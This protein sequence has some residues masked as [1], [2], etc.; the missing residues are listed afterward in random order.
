MNKTAALMLCGLILFGCGK[1]PTSGTKTKNTNNVRT[2]IDI[3][4]G[5]NGQYL[6][7]FEALNEEV[8]GRITGAF[9]FSRDTELDEVVGDV[10]L[11]N[12]GARVVHAQSVRTG[13][14]CPTH[15]D[16][17]NQDGIIDAKEGEA[18]YGK[19]LFPLDGDLSTQS[20]HD[21]EY[22]VGDI[23]G[24]YIYSK[25]SSFTHFVEDLRGPEEYPDYVKLKKD[26]P[27]IIEGK[28]A[29]IQGLNDAIP[30]PLT[31]GTTDRRNR[32]QSLPIACGVIM[33]VQNQP[34]EIQY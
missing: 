32:S 24:N 21:S 20:A 4:A 11:T 14:R 18:V 33:K 23:Y 22:P 29:V 34:G 31:V 2:E 19:I 17:L 27:L 10:R 25:V 13:A 8:T 6:A 28:V 5:V 12:G 26:Q 3:D 16:D 30:L 9:T 7:V 15:N 1:G